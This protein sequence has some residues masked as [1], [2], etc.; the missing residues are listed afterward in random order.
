MGVGVCVRVC[1]RVRVRVHVC[2][3]VRARERARARVVY[4][5]DISNMNTSRATGSIDE[6]P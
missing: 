4:W 6:D 5:Q 1:V 2:V 3:H